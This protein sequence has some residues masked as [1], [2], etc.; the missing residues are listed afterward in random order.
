MPR[1]DG[2]EIGK[3]F[4]PV[5]PACV[6][7]V[8]HFVGAVGGGRG[9]QHVRVGA[10][11]AIGAAGSATHPVTRGVRIGGIVSLVGKVGMRGDPAFVVGMRVVNALGPIQNLRPGKKLQPNYEDSPV[12]YVH[13]GVRVGTSGI[14]RSTPIRHIVRAG[15]GHAGA[16]HRSQPFGAERIVPRPY[17]IQVRV[18][19]S[20]AETAPVFPVVVAKRH[21]LVDAGRVQTAP[22][23]GRHQAFT[24]IYGI[25]AVHAV[26]HADGC[27]NSERHSLYRQVAILDNPVHQFVVAGGLIGTNRSGGHVLRIGHQHNAPRSRSPGQGSFPGRESYRTRTGGCPQEPTTRKLS[28]PL[29][30]R[31][32]MKIMAG[33]CDFMGIPCPHS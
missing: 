21:L 8:P 9:P 4:K 6:A 12:P 14:V 29:L 20:K 22:G 31:R 15:Q 11:A 23:L 5:L 27:L 7:P 24:A 19:A 26:A 16:Q 33:R 18:A 3:R 10:P 30:S 25:G 28:A 17:P 1:K 13:G 32:K 2:G